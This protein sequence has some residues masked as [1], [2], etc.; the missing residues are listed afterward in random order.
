MIKALDHEQQGDHSVCSFVEE[1]LSWPVEK[2]DPPPLLDGQD[3]KQAGFKPGPSF[4]E[5]LGRARQL[6]LDGEL[7]DRSSALLWL[8][9][10]AKSRQ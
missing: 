9:G 4:A 8:E 6:Q 2:R 5:T 7:V 1:V 3:L 10:L